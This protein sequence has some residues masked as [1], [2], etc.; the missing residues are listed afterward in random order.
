MTEAEVKEIAR[1]IISEVMIEHVNNCPHHARYLIDKTRL[2]W[3]FIGVC[4]SS[5]IGT[6]GFMSAILRMFNG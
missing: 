4:I 2:I 6:A 1:E 3:L 5:G